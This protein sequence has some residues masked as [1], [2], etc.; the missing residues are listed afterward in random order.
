MITIVDVQF[1]RSYIHLLGLPPTIDDL[2]D[3]DSVYLPSKWIL[4]I[5]MILYMGI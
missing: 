5:M 1:C 2:E 3:I 4:M